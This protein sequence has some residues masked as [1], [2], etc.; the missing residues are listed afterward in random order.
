MRIKQVNENDIILD[1]DS[2]IVYFDSIIVYFDSIRISSR[3]GS[4]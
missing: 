4:L 2:I 3:K 1:F